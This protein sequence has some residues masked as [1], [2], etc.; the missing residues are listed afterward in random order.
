MDLIDLIEHHRQRIIFETV[1]G[2]RAYGTAHAHSDEDIRGVFVLP[3]TAY[4]SL[5]EPPR[6]VSDSKGDIVYYTLGRFLE[7][8]LKA[9]PNIIELLYMPEDCIRVQTTHWEQVV[10][11]RQSFITK[12]AYASHVGYAQA[13]IKKARGRN[14]WVNRPQ[15]E[16]PPAQEDFCWILPRDTESSV[17]RPYRP[18]PLKTAGIDLTACHATALEH[19]SGLYRL[20]HYGPEAQGVF[21]DG[22]LACESIPLSEEAGRCIG[23]LIYNKGAYERALDDHRHYWDWRRLRNE[24]RW[25]SQER[26]AIDYDAKNMLH[27]FRL[28]LSGEHILREGRPLVRFD[29]P[30]L[31]LL[32]GILAG[33]YGYDE[34]IRMAE[35]KIM[36]LGRLHAASSLPEMPD[37]NRAGE[38]LR[39]LTG[40]W[41]TEHA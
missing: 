25:R 21:R 22:N 24:A 13:Q 9:N 1:A 30:A 36:E 20:Y 17:D 4:L 11:L 3:S 37:Q 2:S 40:A 23:L 38:L 29:G 32:K 39:E 15:P 31:E 41:E 19:T 10:G 14:K 34:L 5:Q 18:Q 28:L 26:G 6:Q 8:A 35:E 12:Q 16:T 7:L 27:T 33:E